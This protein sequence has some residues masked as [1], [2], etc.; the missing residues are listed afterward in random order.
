MKGD[1]R[2]RRD[3]RRCRYNPGVTIGGRPAARLLLPLLL[4]LLLGAEGEGPDPGKL[5]G[6][7]IAGSIVP[8]G[9]IL[10]GGPAR[11]GIR[12]VDQPEFVE[13]AHATWVAAGTPVI[14]VVV[15]DDARAYPI[16]LIEYH[17]IANDRIGGVPVVVTYDP[18]SGTPM[19]FRRKVEGKVLH[20]GVSGLI[21]RSNFLLYDRETESLWSQF[22]GKAIAGPLA[23]KSLPRLRVRQDPMAVW[24]ERQP[25]SKVLV[26]PEP[27]HIDYR[28]SPFSTYWV[29]DK[30]PFPVDEI[31]PRYHPKEVVLG[32]QVEGLTRA[33]L[34]S[35]LT[36]AGGRIVD[37]FR[38]R[39]IRIAYD[40]DSSTFSWDA[41]EDA[42][43]TD[44]YWF[45]W[46]A[47]HPD[48]EIW[49]DQP[50]APED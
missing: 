31:D 15:G 7:E 13:P 3:L 29:S 20:F 8:A 25:R 18:L 6:F 11:D 27:L 33:Y 16:H 9:K 21:Y 2:G 19:V 24:L 36:A 5:N 46:K 23:G 22:L 10:R 1:R 32:I 35:I 38:G 44:A 28:Y 37:D 30:I 12:S 47:F 48:T 43:V 50:R 41:P 17:Q 39:K 4:P 42:M 45:S 49:N 14:G 40:T 26:R 34:G